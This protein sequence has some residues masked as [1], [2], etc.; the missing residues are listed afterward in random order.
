MEFGLIRT[1]SQALWRPL[2]RTRCLPGSFPGTHVPGYINAAAARLLPATARLLPAA[3]RLSHAAA[4]LLHAAAARLSHKQ[5]SGQ[6]SH[7][8]F[9]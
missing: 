3:V 5:P 1:A 2:K 6:R 9:I 4:R 8:N 7:E